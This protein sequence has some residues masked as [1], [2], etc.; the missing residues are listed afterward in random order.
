M[1]VFYLLLLHKLMHHNYLLVT[2]FMHDGIMYSYN[3]L[4]MLYEFDYQVDFYNHAYLTRYIYYLF[5]VVIEPLLHLLFYTYDDEYIKFILI[6]TLTPYIF[7]MITTCSFAMFI[8][9]FIHQC[10]KK[11]KYDII[12]NIIKHIC[13]I[14]LDHDPHLTRKEVAFLLKKN[15]QENMYL[16]VK[17]FIVLIVVQTASNGNTYL[18][19]LIKTFYNKNNNNK[20]T[21]P[22][23]K[24]QSDIEKIKMI[25]NKRQWDAFC[26]PYIIHVIGNIYNTKE[27]TNTYEIWFK[28]IETAFIK[29]FIGVTIAKILKID[30]YLFLGIIHYLLGRQIHPYIPIGCM[31]GWLFNSY[32]VTFMICEYGNF[33]NPCIMW[34]WNNMNIRQYVPLLYHM[35]D[36]NYYIIINVLLGYHCWFS[37]FNARYPLITVWFFAF[38]YLSNYTYMHMILLGIIL[39][40]GINIYY[41]KDKPKDKINIVPMLNYNTVTYEKIVQKPLVI[42]DNYDVKKIDLAKEAP[43]IPLKNIIILN[44]LYNPNYTIVP[45]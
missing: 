29:V 21:D 39:Y 3:N 7:N 20:Y 4:C 11:I 18:L 19:R 2:L 13:L 22:Y 43:I 8:K 26:N 16:F 6:L 44:T 10:G 32:Y 40:L 27:S 41:V 25:V 36:F 34:C 28:M 9:K 42:M 30:N 5:L 31:L 1:F 15:H 24:V 23:P 17:N 33:F 45:I 37:L 12:K 38:G 35:N 14:V